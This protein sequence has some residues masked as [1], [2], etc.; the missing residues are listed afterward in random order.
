MGKKV[1]HL[2]MIQ[3]VIARLSHN[4]FLIKGWTITLISAFIVIEKSNLNTS[5]LYIAV[6]PT[7]LFWIIDSYFLYQERLFRKLFN[8]VRLLDEKKI[9]FSMDTKKFKEITWIKTFFSKTLFIF[10]GLILLGLTILIL[11]GG[12]N[13]G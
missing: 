10:Y 11:Y 5:L 3:N 2:E 6:F 7:L 4:S 1:S 12:N 13:C 8:K 9:D